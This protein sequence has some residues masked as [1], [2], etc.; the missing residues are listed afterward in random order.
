MALDGPGIFTTLIPTRKFS[1]LRTPILASLLRN[2]AICL[3]V[4]G[5]TILQ[6]SLVALGLPGWRSPI[7]S[8]FGVPDPGGG[9]TR[10]I[11]A[12]LRGDWQTSLTFHAFAPFFIVALTLIAVAAVLPSSPRDK[13]SDWVENV[14]V[15]T[16]LT[17]I[18]LIGLVVYWLVRLLILGKTYI[19][20]I[21]G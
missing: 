1:A 9:L 21:T 2:R 18:L 11:V 10:A 3:V 19:T 12:F 16:G 17:A 13:I 7:L 5:V 20:L 4:T 14:E 6:L 8:F 15:R